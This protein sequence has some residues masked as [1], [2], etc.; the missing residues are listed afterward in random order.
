M[1]PG[2]DK[3]AAAEAIGTSNVIQGKLDEYDALKQLIQDCNVI[4]FEIE[5]IGVSALQRLAAE[6]A[7]QGRTLNIQPSIKIMQ[8]IQDKLLQKTFFQEHNIPLPPFIQISSIQDIHDARETLGLPIMLK[9]RAAMMAEEMPCSK[10]FL[11]KV[12]PRL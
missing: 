4:T 3:S 12:Y 2:G 11:L 1:D 8:T 7:E 10:I 9:R 6:E 5:H